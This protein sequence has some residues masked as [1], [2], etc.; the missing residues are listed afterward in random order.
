[1]SEAIPQISQKWLPKDELDKDKN[2]HKAY[3]GERLWDLKYTQVV[4][5]NLGILGSGEIVFH[6]EEHK[7]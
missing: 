3:S 5:G 4:R 2:R 7:N 6:K 1:M